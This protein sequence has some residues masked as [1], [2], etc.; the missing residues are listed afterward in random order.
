[1]TSPPVPPHP[2]KPDPSMFRLVLLEGRGRAAIGIAAVISF[3]IA[4]AVFAGVFR[5]VGH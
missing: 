4:L 5:L 3:T 1:M 2:E